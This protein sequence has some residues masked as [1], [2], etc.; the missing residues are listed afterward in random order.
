MIMGGGTANAYAHIALNTTPENPGVLGSLR[1][2]FEKLSHGSKAPGHSDPEQMS[3]VVLV[4]KPSKIV[5]LI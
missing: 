1:G 5:F 4:V 3:S 2:I